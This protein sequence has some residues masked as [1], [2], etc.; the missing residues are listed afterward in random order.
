MS[1]PQDQG[2][3]GQHQGEMLFW[4]ER[5]DSIA[6]LQGMWNFISSRQRDR[7]GRGPRCQH[8]DRERGHRCT[9]PRAAGASPL[10]RV[11]P[12]CWFHLMID[13]AQE[14]TALVKGDPEQI[15]APFSVG[16]ILLLVEER[17]LNESTAPEAHEA[18]SGICDA[19]MEWPPPRPRKRG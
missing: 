5:G 12:Y 4:D 9:F 19:L 1:T 2:K 3:L 18:L 17:S 13:F 16:C 15:G 11:P 14:L 6:W 8:E 10:A 7:D